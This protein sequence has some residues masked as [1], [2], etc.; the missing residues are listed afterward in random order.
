MQI[1]FI[2]HYAMF[3]LCSQ[4]VSYSSVLYAYD[5]CLFVLLTGQSVVGACLT[6]FDSYVYIMCCEEFKPSR[7][8]KCGGFLSYQAACFRGNILL[9][10]L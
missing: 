8:S 7:N 5:C 6:C 10:D 4:A 9:G 1:Y 3:F 2:A